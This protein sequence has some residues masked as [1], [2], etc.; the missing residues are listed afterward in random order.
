[1]TIG[2]HAA[3]GGTPPAGGTPAPTP[4]APA[5]P[6]PVPVA[7][8][9]VPTTP[10]APASAAPTAPTHQPWY[11]SFFPNSFRFFSGLG[12]LAVSCG[13]GIGG[14]NYISSKSNPSYDRPHSIQVH[15]E[16][17]HRDG[18][19]LERYVIFGGERYFS[20]FNGRKLD[21]NTPR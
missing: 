9:P 8:T 3:A 17:I 13:L 10:A 15:G 5:A 14:C 7:P 11:T 6:T 4:A 21:T 2:A 1:M 12:I 20:E 16:D 18:S 19:G